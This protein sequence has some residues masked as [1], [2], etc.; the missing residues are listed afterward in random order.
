MPSTSVEGAPDPRPV[1]GVGHVGHRQ[2]ETGTAAER[3]GERVRHREPLQGRAHAFEPRQPRVRGQ[4]VVGQQRRRPV[5]RLQVGG[6]PGTEHRHRHEPGSEHAAHPPQQAVAPRRLG[7]VRRRWPLAL[8]VGQPT[9][10]V[11]EHGA[12]RH[13]A[14]RPRGHGVGVAAGERGEAGGDPEP[15][16]GGERTAHRDRRSGMGRRAGRPVRRARH[17]AP[18][19]RR[20]SAT[21]AR[22]GRRVG[23]GRRAP[24]AGRRRRGAGS[25]RPGGAPRPPPR[26]GRRD[27]GRCGRRPARARGA[28]RPASRPTPCRAPRRTP[29]GRARWRPRRRR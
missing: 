20:R 29:A 28:G 22:R 21:R 2:V 11:G 16:S 8:G 6:R 7:L 12:R 19:G 18:A 13:E 23:R 27:R 4:R 9:G 5:P 1:A 25:R 10:G 26:A 14:G 24:A 3:A 15:G 17:R